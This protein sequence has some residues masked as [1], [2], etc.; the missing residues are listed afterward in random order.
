[1]NKILHFTK[2]SFLLA[3]SILMLASGITFAQSS[4]IVEPGLNT[5]IDAI[6]AH[7]GDTLI[8]QKGKEY[9]IDQEIQVTAP[10]VIRGEAYTLEDTDPPALM[11]MYADPGEASDKFMFAA[12]ADLHLIDLGF[13]GFT[14]DNQQIFGVCEISAPNLNITAEGCIVQSVNTWMQ[15]N[16]V[17]GTNYLLH[18]NI[19]FNISYVGWDN[20]GG[21]GGPT[22]KGDSIINHS[23]NNTYF[24]GGRT[25]A[26][27][28]TGP[29]GGQY[30]DHNTYVNTFG[31][32]FH[33][34]KDKNFHLT[35]S[36][37]HNTHLRGYVGMRIS[38]NDTIW[39]GDYVSYKISGVDYYET[40]D[41]LNGDF[42]IFPHILDSVGGPREVIVTNNLKFNEQRVLD[43]NVEHSVSTQPFVARNVLAFGKRYGWTIENNWM[44][45][46]STSFDPLFE[47]G[48]IPI[49]AFEKSWE[50]RINR[51]IAG[52]TPIEV[53]WR[54]GGEE[55]KDFIWPL[56][57]DF[58]P[59]N[60]AALTAGTDGYPL[61][62][63]NWFGKDVVEAWENGWPLP[64]EAL[65]MKSMELKL[66]NYPNP[67]SSNTH[68]RYDLPA[69]SH[70]TLKI[71]DITGSEVA[72]LVNE[73][74]VA[75]HHEMMF[76]GANLSGG[77]YFCK[78][79]AGNTIQLNKMILI[80]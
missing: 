3:S 11:R 6:A 42:A 15:T 63:L 2:K 61:G 35:N 54:P 27:A 68:I 31:E 80:K 13:I 29:N 77:I 52:S 57:F 25:M 60:D 12:A 48:E 14:F 65:K 41:T 70:V 30:L 50:Q 17:P 22:Y 46:D 18:D 39:D 21:F 24:V 62:D 9:V 64:V 32:T 23:Y 45:Q 78:I 58:T 43:W 75:G 36:I 34:C 74:Q 47:M 37:L 33:K 55:Q 20:W 79:K 76:D 28:G 10:L 71:Y 1:M 5:I 66:G 67:F 51:M 56:P 49:G 72:I 7:P 59:T 26:S 73:T 44:D 19:H 40:G 69:R 4:V 38:G 16:K 53:A 8:L